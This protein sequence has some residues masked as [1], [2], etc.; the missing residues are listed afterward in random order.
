MPFWRSVLGSLLFFW[1][2]GSFW[3]CIRLLVCFCSVGFGCSSGVQ[4][5][6]I[7]FDTMAY[8]SWNPFLYIGAGGEGH[9]SCG[10]RGTCSPR[11][12]PAF[13]LPSS[14]RKGERSQALGTWFV[15]THKG[16]GV[17]STDSCENHCWKYEVNLDVLNCGDWCHTAK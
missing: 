9:S 4:V 12:S 10:R 6:C 7:C 11:P 2:H 17:E 1:L 8:S 3:F 16:V 5:R 14:T 15:A 13:S